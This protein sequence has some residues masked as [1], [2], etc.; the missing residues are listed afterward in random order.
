MPFALTYITAFVLATI[1]LKYSPDTS[2]KTWAREEIKERKEE[3]D[4]QRLLREIKAAKS[5]E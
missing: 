4:A 5:H 1:G 2:V 3:Q